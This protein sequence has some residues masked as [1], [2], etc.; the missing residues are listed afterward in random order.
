MV[1][2]LSIE[3]EISYNELKDNIPTDHTSNDTELPPSIYFGGSAWGSAFYVGVYQGLVDRFGP[4]FKDNMLVCGDSAGSIIA[5]AVALDITPEHL[6]QI[7]YTFAEVARQRGLWFGKA[8]YI[9]DGIIMTTLLEDDCYKKLN[10]ML[11]VGHTEFPF[12]HVFHSEWSSD[13]ELFHCLRG[14]LH[15]PTYASFDNI[16]YKGKS[17]VDG[18][19]SLK[20]A[21]FPHG[22][23]TL[24]IGFD[25]SADI[26]RPMNF[27]QL[28]YPASKSEFFALVQS[29]YDAVFEW[30]GNMKNKIGH[31]KQNYKALLLF[32]PLRMVC[33][34]IRLCITL[35]E[36]LFCCLFTMEKDLPYNELKE[37]FLKD[38]QLMDVQ[39]NIQGRRLH[40]SISNQVTE[41][42]NENSS[43]TSS[44]ELGYLPDKVLRNESVVLNVSSEKVGGEEGIHVHSHDVL[45]I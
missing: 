13:E 28:V 30:D 10:G 5:A 36:C 16:R 37:Q 23:S 31:R 20:G 15:I 26:T 4:N 29:G 34:L 42:P 2:N 8:K 27:S 18:A 22:D 32:W 39:L 3:G 6:G 9:V 45:T 35:I 40:K 12:K 24:F 19:F 17:P 7:H 11:A 21:D 25:P 44:V 33:K 43:D 1:E 38:V 14:S 41:D